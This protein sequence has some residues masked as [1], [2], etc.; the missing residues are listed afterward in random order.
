VKI[1]GRRLLRLSRISDPQELQHRVLEK[2]STVGCP[3]SRMGIATA[4]KKA[5]FN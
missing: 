2:E 4:L 3:L 5:K 1:A